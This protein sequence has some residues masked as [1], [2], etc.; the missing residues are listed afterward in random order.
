V[1][2]IL[3]LISMLV[4]PALAFAV[5]GNPADPQAAF[6]EINKSLI[7]WM[8]GPLGTGLGVTMLVMGGAIA[9]AKNSPMPAL[10]GVAGAAFLHFAPAIIMNI[11]APQGDIQEASNAATAVVASATVAASAPT[12][13]AV[14]ALAASKALSAQVTSPASAPVPVASTAS[15]APAVPATPKFLAEKPVA[16]PAVASQPAT[17]AAIVVQVASQPVTSHAAALAH[18][19]PVPTA[20]QPTHHVSTKSV[21]SSDLTKW[22]GIAGFAVIL[23]LLGLLAYLSS[24]RKSKDTGFTP[25]ATSGAGSVF[26]DPHGFRREKNPSSLNP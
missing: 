4:V 12:A 14:A 26:T 25:S 1:K 7:D 2:K 19:V 16:S 24:R 15:V 11:M 5:S 21:S 13:S 8:T 10:T 17:P 9:V 23:S 22:L 20:M 18:T 3:L 6:A